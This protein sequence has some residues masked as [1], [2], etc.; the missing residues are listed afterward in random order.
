MEFA[1][2]PHVLAIGETLMDCVQPY[3]ET[4]P[5]NEYPGGSPAN[6]AMTLGRLDRPVAL[7]TWI[8]KDSRGQKIVEHFSASKVH[9][10]ED[11]HGA[12]HTS[13]ALAALNER[14]A[15]TYTFDF[16]W[17]PP[18]PME[19]TGNEVLVHAGSISATTEP[20]A[21]TVLDA[22]IRAR[23]HAL[24]TYDPNARPTLMGTPEQAMAQV[25]RFVAVAD[26]V[27]VSDE[28]IEW[29]TGCSDLEKTVQQWLNMGPQ[30]I[31]VTRGKKG[32]VA[33]TA[34]GLYCTSTPADVKVVDTVGAGDSFMGGI[35]DAMWG[36]GLVG[37]AAR[38]A[39]R[40]VTA[41]QVDAILAHASAVSD[42]TVS[43]A[44]ANPP[45]RHELN[46]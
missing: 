40:N 26:V 34:S 2:E 10:T 6:V 22:L 30:V 41:E 43:R 44:G 35:I 24:I 1:N 39:L 29:L 18:H 8:G 23:R 21:T 36:L 14:G 19:L 17:N 45:W 31:I 42:V 28:D 16:V 9:I 33:Y 32:G 11:S 5:T 25:S 27:K 37:S 3:G 4:E 46:A 20:G 12:D 7:R 13:T 38:P 15:A